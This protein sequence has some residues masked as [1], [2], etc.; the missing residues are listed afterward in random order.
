VA[1]PVEYVPLPHCSQDHG[2]GSLEERNLPAGHALQCEAPVRSPTPS[3]SPALAAVKWPGWHG[4]Q[5]SARELPATPLKRPSAQPSQYQL[6]ATLLYEPAGHGLQCVASLDTPT[7]SLSPLESVAK[8]PA[9]HARQ[10]S[11]PSEPNSPVG[12]AP[13]Q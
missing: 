3:M 7:P 4:P 9:P 2:D 11:P 10:S 1:E 5:P 6:L 12:Q 13:P 8:E